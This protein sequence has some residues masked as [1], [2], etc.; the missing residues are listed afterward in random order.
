[1]VLGFFWTIGIKNGAVERDEGVTKAWADVESQY[2]R[3]FDLI[4]DG[5]VDRV[6]L[7]PGLFDI[8]TGLVK[9]WKGANRSNGSSG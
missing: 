8:D 4:D 7:R 3:R 5:A 9:R 1:M 2:Q 6:D